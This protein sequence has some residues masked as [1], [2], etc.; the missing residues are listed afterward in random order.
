M[1][2][3]AAALRWRNEKNQALYDWAMRIAARRGRARACVA[4]ARKMAGILYAMWRDGTEFDPLAI[5][6][7]E[8]SPDIDLRPFPR[9]I[10]LRTSGKFAT[11]CAGANTSRPAV[12]LLTEAAPSLE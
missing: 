3:L 8:S 11:G 2:R 10:R 12:T 9:I 5:K 6:L 1:K 7:T 4:L